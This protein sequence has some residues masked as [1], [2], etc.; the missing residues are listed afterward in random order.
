MKYAFDFTSTGVWH[1][2]NGNLRQLFVFATS[3][4]S[5]FAFSQESTTYRLLNITLDTYQPERLQINHGRLIW[6]DKDFTPK[7]VI[8]YYTE[9]NI[10]ARFKHQPHGSQTM[11]LSGT[12][13]LKSQIIQY[14]DWSVTTIEVYNPNYKQPV[15]IAEVKLLC[16]PLEAEQK[17]F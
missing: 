5:I 6:I 13:R 15:A 10:H 7:P 17:F 14:R 12:P 9:Q 8:E 4:V 3:I 1:V 11:I 2:V 16:E